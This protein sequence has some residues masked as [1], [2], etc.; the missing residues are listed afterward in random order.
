MDL[1]TGRVPRS[2][3]LTVSPDPIDARFDQFEEI[4]HLG[5]GGNADVT[6]QAYRGRGPDVVAL[7][8]P[9]MQGTMDVAS[10][11]Q[12]TD[13]AKTWAK[14]DDHRHIVGVLDYDSDPLP[15]IALEYMDRGSLED[16]VGEMAPA[17]A[18]WTSLC[19][20]RAVRHAHR[21]GVAHLDL[22]PTNVLF[23][24]TG[25]GLWD[26]PKVADWGLAKMLL[27]HS[28][29]VEGMSPHYAAPEQFD[30]ETYGAADD[31]TD[32]Y[33]IGALVY[34]S[35]VGDPPFTGA[36]ASVMKQIL[37]DQP[38]PP[39]DRVDRLP[40][41]TDAV[42]LQ[43]LAK[44]K[45][46]RYESVLDLRR[47]LETLVRRALGDET[48][49]S[50]IATGGTPAANGSATLG[51]ATSTTDSQTSSRTN[52]SHRRSAPRSN[53]NPESAAADGTATEERS[54][55]EDLFESQSADSTADGQHS[56][57]KTTETTDI[58]SMLTNAV[59]PPGLWVSLMVLAPL[60]GFAVGGSTHW[61]V[62]AGG[63]L[64]GAYAMYRDMDTLAARRG[65]WNPLEH[66]NRYIVGMLLWYVT[67]PY[68][69]YKRSRHYG[70]LD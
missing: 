37:T 16:R 43:C 30:S 24:S 27:E 9:R 65:E 2:D 7:K 32:V 52:A 35:L 15:W 34:A 8:Q 4:E 51:S 62:T 28:K 68:Y 55:F 17:G 31:L 54:T 60:A 57:H 42:V 12:F 21:R 20:A 53:E 14:L 26:T 10:V 40:T 66:R 18:L 46:N 1:D 33:A 23:T 45:E 70:L 11:E 38:T 25:P 69:L 44:Q 61:T 63:L 5:S 56:G 6:K 22:K 29:S 59:S 39:S 3:D 48:D 19:V 50:L 58:E 41:G 64:G 49:G 13:E 67:V 47:D 36:S